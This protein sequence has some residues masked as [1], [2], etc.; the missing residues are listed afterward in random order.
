MRYAADFLHAAVESV[1]YRIHAA[2]ADNG[3]TL[4]MRSKRIGLIEQGLDHRGIN[5]FLLGHC[6]GDDRA[7][8][9]IYADTQLPLRSRS[10]G[11]VV[12]S[13]TVRVPSHFKPV[14]PIS[15]WSG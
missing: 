13:Q 6:D 9:G 8:D 3:R 15:R 11:A 4:L 7:V 5:D 2:L 1:P 10:R 14:R 12:F